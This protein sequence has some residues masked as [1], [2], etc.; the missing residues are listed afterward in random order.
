MEA[1]TVYKGLVGDVERSVWVGHV[2]DALQADKAANGLR[3][4][5]VP[6]ATQLASVMETR[7][8]REMVSRQILRHT[9]EALATLTKAWNREEL[10]AEV[11][12]EEVASPGPTELDAITQL[13]AACIVAR[14]V[15]EQHL[16]VNSPVAPESLLDAVGLMHSVLL[17]VPAQDQL[18][19][20]GNLQDRIAQLCEWIWSTEQI[21][22]ETIVAQSLPYLIM[23]CLETEHTTKGF[24]KGTAHDVARLFKVRKALSLLDFGDEENIEGIRELLLACAAS[25]LFVKTRPAR[26][27]LAYL[28]SLHAPLIPELHAAIKYQLTL[29]RKG[30]LDG[31]GEVYFTAW[32]DGKDITLDATELC[33]QDLMRSACLVSDPSVAKAVRR[34]LA[35]FHLNKTEK[36]VDE[37][38]LRL[39]RPILFRLLC[40]PNPGVRQRTTQIF[41]DAFPL[42]P[43]PGLPDRETSLDGRDVTLLQR[44][45]DHFDHLLADDAPAVRCAAVE[46]VCRIMGIYWERI[47]PAI[48][49]RFLRRLGAEL[50][51][52]SSSG[53][54]RVCV[55]NSFAYLLDYEPCQATLKAILPGLAPLG[56]DKDNRVRVAL[57]D[58]L[59]A[60]KP[61]RALKPTDVLSL[62]CLLDMLAADRNIPAVTS[63]LTRVLMGGFLQD[64]ARLVQ[65]VRR[66]PVEGLTLCK[67]LGKEA[68]PSEVVQ[69][70]RYML[71]SLTDVPALN[72]RGVCTQRIKEHDVNVQ[73]PDI[74][75]KRGR[76]GSRIS[77]SSLTW[78]N[79]DAQAILH[80][81]AFLWTGCAEVLLDTGTSSTPLKSSQVIFKDF[82]ED[83]I[84]SLDLEHI[85]LALEDAR[86][87]GDQL[88][89]ALASAFMFAANILQFKSE[90][91][92]HSGLVNETM[93]HAFHNLHLLAPDYT[94]FSYAPQL[95]YIFYGGQR[96]KLLNS[97]VAGVHGTIP[98]SNCQPLA[99]CA[100]APLA[101]WGYPST[102]IRCIQFLFASERVRP[103]LLS[104]HA[105]V[106]TTL[107]EVLRNLTS[108]AKLPSVNESDELPELLILEEVAVTAWKASLHVSFAYTNIHVGSG[109]YE[110]IYPLPGVGALWNEILWNVLAKSRDVGKIESRAL[111][112]VKLGTQLACWIACL[113]GE[114]SALGLADKKELLEFSCNCREAINMCK[115]VHHSQ[116]FDL[117]NFECSW[118]E[119]DH[120]SAI[121]FG[122]SCAKLA[123]ALASARYSEESDALLL[124]NLL[125]DEGEMT[126]DNAESDDD[127]VVSAQDDR[128]LPALDKL[129]ANL[130]HVLS[131]AKG[132]ILV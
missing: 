116:A 107:G 40:A 69:A 67:Q 129:E 60:I 89:P 84:N 31:Y 92:S 1:Q 112:A 95:L 12:T 96:D 64:T 45:F 55:I 72:P 4:G 21:G 36:G 32:K 126:A 91:R 34:V 11:R 97:L 66:H 111:E 120:M 20:S 100:K 26:R 53:E 57:C 24:R 62:E 39:Y 63:R 125:Q 131:P 108:W 85:I 87:H 10:G 115:A 47:P 94:V 73:T 122:V 118:L 37:L 51:F 128:D 68:D 114:A 109:E 48:I 110:A 70:M 22:R 88:A 105:M 44:Q 98:S 7:E 17:Q 65:L 59:L 124:M 5:A 23:R 6:L 121:S 58:L 30:A 41:V 78:V 83:V 25:P 71:K 42:V 61:L 2:L 123:Q 101:S 79:P 38:L 81:L 86:D 113:F 130:A 15:C 103:W 8:S 43:T 50:A 119:R 77:G 90:R 127:P 104:C 14:A 27:F 102:A 29:C 106:L 54:V 49:A 9:K 52:D 93:E 28:F 82:A 16:R 74:G 132:G 99:T 3:Q 80:V 56:K 117:D 75:V 46:G 19:S 13:D 33:V 18:T 76:T 35:V